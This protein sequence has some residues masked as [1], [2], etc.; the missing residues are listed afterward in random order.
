MMLDDSVRR[1]TEEEMAILKDVST[2]SG[3]PVEDLKKVWR[4][5]SFSIANIASTGSTNKTVIPK[6]VTADI[7]MR[8]V[9]DQELKVI[10]E[11]LEEFCKM[12]FED[13]G[14]E[15]GFE[16][17]LLSRLSESSIPDMPG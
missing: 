3:R 11:G 16:V 15:N 12:T 9:P 4:E 1:V 8:I 13:L 2:A 7:S 14:S 5:P 6:R 17:S 10:T